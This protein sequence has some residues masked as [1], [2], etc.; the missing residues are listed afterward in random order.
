[1]T[2]CWCLSWRGRMC[3]ASV[4]TKARG[5]SWMSPF[6]WFNWE[7]SC[8]SVS[9]GSHIYRLCVFL[10]LC[11]IVTHVVS[12]SQNRLKSCLFHHYPQVQRVVS[13]STGRPD[14]WFQTVSLH[15]FLLFN[16]RKCACIFGA[17]KF[18][19]ITFWEAGYHPGQVAGP[20]QGDTETNETHNHARSLLRT[21]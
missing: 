3:P 7:L 17:S 16:R 20:S 12:L 5:T 13:I 18:Q 1:M 15:A 21:I 8:F 6:L 2:S 9:A 4:R 11:P 14:R 10:L 19:H